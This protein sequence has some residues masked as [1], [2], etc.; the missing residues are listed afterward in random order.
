RWDTFRAYGPT[1]ARFDHHQ[2]P[3][4][5][6]ERRILYAAEHVRACLAEVFQRRRH[7][8]TAFGEPWL[9]GFALAA[10]LRLLNLTGA[11]PTRAG[12]SMAINSGPRPRARRW[13]RAIYETYPDAQGL[14]CGSSMYRNTPGVALFE[15]A[16]G[17]LPA[18]PLF[19]RALADPLLLPALADAADELG[20]T[21]SAGAPRDHE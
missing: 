5:V 9:V 4:G 19:H 16:A 2:P 1:D 18:R 20:Y 14:Y 17:A 10:P 6:Q 13:S 7:I 21:L 3:P 8:D 11:W 15:R 12:A